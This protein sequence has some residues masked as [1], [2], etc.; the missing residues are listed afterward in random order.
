M[1]S[2]IT[3]RNHS[4]EALREYDYVRGMG[5]YRPHFAGIPEEY[6]PLSGC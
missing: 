6:Y 4:I 5:S 2:N 1:A 3:E